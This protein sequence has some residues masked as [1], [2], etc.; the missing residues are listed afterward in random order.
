MIRYPEALIGLEEEITIRTKDWLTRAEERTQK[1]ITAGFYYEDYKDPGDS[2]GKTRTL[3]PFWGEVKSIY[4][5]RQHNKCIYCEKKLEGKEFATIEWDLEHFRPKG[6]IRKWPP[7]KKDFGYDFSTG[8]AFDTGYYQFAYHPHNYAA[9]CKTCNSPFKSDHFPIAADR[10]FGK[11]APAECLAEQS[12]LTYP[13][14]TLDEDPSTLIA[15]RGLEAIPRFQKD[16]DA[17]RWKRG[18][19]MIDFFGLNRDG[20]IYD[21][22]WWIATAV[23]PTF[24]LAE[25]EGLRDLKNLN[26]VRSERAPFSNCTRCFIDLCTMDRPAAEAMIREFDKIVDVMEN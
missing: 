8:A 17:A 18:R 26:R 20:L 3:A 22:A 13:L 4:I 5:R 6:R 11:Q 9:A 2:S 1:F 7:R 21:R 16:D 25:K 10:V 15:F 19:V 24:L 12:F 23:W 14:G